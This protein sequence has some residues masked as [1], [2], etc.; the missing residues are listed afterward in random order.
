MFQ[1]AQLRLIMVAQGEPEEDLMQQ[2][3]MVPRLEV[4]EEAQK[5]VLSQELQEM[6]VMEHR[7]VYV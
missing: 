5:A 4:E 7:D 6:V 1:V 3:E 2:E